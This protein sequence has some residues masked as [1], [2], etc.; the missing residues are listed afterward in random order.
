M[1]ILGT[2][3]LTDAETVLIDNIAESKELGT[4]SDTANLRDILRELRFL[5]INMGE[6]TDTHFTIDDVEEDFPQ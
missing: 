1:A 2:R 3:C 4:A 6:A 5:N